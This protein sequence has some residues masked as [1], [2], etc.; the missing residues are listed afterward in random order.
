MCVCVCVC[1]CPPHYLTE[2][3]RAVGQLLQHVRL[4]PQVV[5][6]VAQV[7]L[8]AHQGHAQLIV[9]PADGGDDRGERG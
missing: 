3:V 5:V 1:V 8:P 6:G 4:F 7:H 9:Q 2:G